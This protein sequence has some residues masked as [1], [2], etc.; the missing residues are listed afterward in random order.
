[1]T[2]EV[3]VIESPC[4]DPKW[5][6]PAVANCCDPRGCDRVFNDQFAQRLARRYRRR[7]LDPTAQRI[8]DLIAEQGLD[9]ATVL[10]VGGGIGAIQVELLKRGAA[11]TTNLEL[12]P[13]Y[14]KEARQLL[15]EAGLADR[16]ERRIIDIAAAPDDV[17]P[18]DVVVL[19]RVVC[20][21]PDYA[22]LLGAA[23][24][25]ARRQVI[26]SHPPRNLASQAILGAQNL[27]FRLRGSSFRV[28]VHPPKAMLDILA[29]RG[30]TTATVRR[31]A[32][33]R[34]A[35]ASVNPLTR[36]GS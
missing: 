11:R 30:L 18:A 8:V 13:A 26:F 32:V 24:G 35:A 21:Y 16:A 6:N 29:A 7:G 19:H 1:V 36:P 28:F 3:A 10:E 14:E 25:H 9:G 5:D 17:E 4:R 23:A 33:W 15:R 31:N 27:Y 2:G 20:C 12:S 34:I 22:K